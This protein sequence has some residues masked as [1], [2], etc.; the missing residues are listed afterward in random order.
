MP[1][2]LGIS[3]GASGVGAAL[4]VDTATGLTSEYRR[5]A[6]DS[7]HRR[8]VGDLV[9]DAISLMTTQVVDQPV[10]DAVTVAYRTEEQA[11]AIRTAA[12]RHG[13]L[14][15]LVPETTAL[16]AYL[17]TVGVRTEPGA[18]AIADIG[19]S[20]TTV[21]VL[22]QESGTVLRSARTESVSGNAVGTVIY[23]HVHRAT[24]RMRTRMQVDP[25]LLKARCQGAQEV[26]TTSERTR[27]DIAEAGP[28]AS[29][30]LTRADLAA[31]AAELSETAAAFTRQV[32]TQSLPRPGTLALVGGTAAV[33]ALATAVTDSFDGHVITVPEPA[34][35]AAQG[36]AHLSD[37]A[38]FGGYDVVGSAKA[39]S[40]SAGARMSGAVAA[41]LVLAAVVA[42]F[43]TD[44]FTD[45]TASTPV[46]PAGTDGVVVTED[47][48]QP[49]YPTETDIPS[50]DPDPSLSPTQTTDGDLDGTPLPAP[51][52]STVPRTN[53]PV[54]SGNSTATPTPIDQVQT[55]E[56]APDETPDKWR[57][58]DSDESTTSQPRP[59][60]PIR[61]TPQPRPTRPTPRLRNPGRASHPSPLIQR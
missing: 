55:L 58:H 41:A 19:A 15:R 30:T 57:P 11:D 49:S 60:R 51:P 22:D 47:P 20:G 2:S 61:P 59:I 37:S 56:S 29:V 39:S 24:H 18:V 44:K 1:T 6:V 50:S 43:A 48:S 40:T 14:V 12:E 46:S 28:D 35:A 34:S 53:I 27:I 21:S 32:T 26:L 17:R 4:L 54:T 5:L 9:F 38:H 52:P 13:R 31:L 7:G 33:P 42:G 36:A 16:L 23:D 10:P 8:D 3:V 45:R 25:A